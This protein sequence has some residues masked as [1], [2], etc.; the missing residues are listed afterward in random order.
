MCMD[1]IN[2][3]IPHSSFFSFCDCI[4]SCNNPKLTLFPTMYY[5]SYTAERDRESSGCTLSERRSR[6]SGRTSRSFETRSMIWSSL[7]LEDD[8]DCCLELPDDLLL[9]DITAAVVALPGFDPETRNG[10]TSCRS[11]RVRLSKTDQRNV[12]DIRARGR[13]RG[14]Q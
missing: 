14:R 7:I 3:H 6:I 5:C 9:P 2:D 1:E 11:R 4:V 13:K 12:N 10:F 8:P